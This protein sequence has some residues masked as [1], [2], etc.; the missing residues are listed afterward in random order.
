MTYYQLLKKPVDELTY[1][2]KMRLQRAEKIPPSVRR[3]AEGRLTELTS[4]VRK[5]EEEIDELREWL[6]GY[7]YDPNG[8]IPF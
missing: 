3:I 4:Q 5:L 2:E 8:K 1:D 7:D 6:D